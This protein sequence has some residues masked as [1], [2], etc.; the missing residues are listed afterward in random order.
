[1][2]QF[3]RDPL[4]ALWIACAISSGYSHQVFG[5]YEVHHHGWEARHH[6]DDSESVPWDADTED[7]GTLFSHHAVTAIGDCVMITVSAHH[8][9]VW[10]VSQFLQFQPDVCPAA[11]EHPPQNV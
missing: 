4:L 10:A 9:E 7:D 8:T 2:F 3:F 11:I 5:K 6:G 1:V